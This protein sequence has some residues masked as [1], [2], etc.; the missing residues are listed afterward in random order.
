MRSDRQGMALL[1][2]LVL[3]TLAALGSYGYTFHM[4]SQYR[5]V[6][7][8][9]DQIHAQL[10]ADSGFE[11]VAS[12]LEQPTD[13]RSGF[14]SLLNNPELFQDVPIE[15]SDTR[16]LQAVQ[17]AGWRFSVISP[18]TDGQDV[19]GSDSSEV[20][21]AGR[22]VTESIRRT[23]DSGTLFR[24]GLENE[25]AKIHV[26]TLLAWDRQYPGH[27][28]KVLMQLPNAS[29]PIVQA[30]LRWMN[31]QPITRQ[32]GDN[33]IGG[34]QATAQQSMVD[35]QTGDGDLSFRL[36]DNWLGGDWNQDFQVDLLDQAFR[37]RLRGS[38]RLATRLPQ[39]SSESEGA[40]DQQNQGETLAAWKAWQRYLTWHSGSRNESANG[41][42][43]VD[44]NQPNLQE[45]H[46]RLLEIWP[47]A[48]AD[49][50]VVYRQYGASPAAPANSGATSA[51][52]GAASSVAR[53]PSPVASPP[54]D[55]SI[56]PRFL[57][58]SPLE[59]VGAVVTLPTA[60]GKAAEKSE[61][62]LIP[63]PFG[64]GNNEMS[65]YLGKLL[66]QVT[67]GSGSVPEGRL[68]IRHAS[69]WALLAVPGIDTTTAQAI[70]QRRS[71]KTS[72]A[73]ENYAT[74]A[75]LIEEGVVDLRK[76]IQIEPYLTAR[77]D[78][79]SCQIV[80]YRDDRSPMFRCTAILDASRGQVVRRCYQ[81]W[82]QWG[83]QLSAADLN[84]ELATSLPTNSLSK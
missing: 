72:D 29:Q 61:K 40:V 51:N 74:I 71:D 41:R 18:L 79:Y 34:T 7:V 75:W 59:L 32:A 64:G 3:V 17:S 48:W 42:R 5:R 73:T 84:S 11:L 2:V 23:S 67:T 81:R 6:S 77:S 21:F 33:S 78:V 1:I 69:A 82:H 57:L 12:I 55:F 28:Q 56:A 47:S 70:L 50:V 4:Q 37:P 30:W 49:F 20:S 26:P 25:S 27:A 31:V 83:G 13:Q 16:G 44:L 15:Q 63:S 68:D 58:R 65:N 36:H 60:S 46:R 43:R 24:F 45:L 10:A 38:Q 62:R 53:P 22:S 80:G 8:Q 52:L 39:S 66:D 14:G 76:M 35:E 54:M 9:E 19:T